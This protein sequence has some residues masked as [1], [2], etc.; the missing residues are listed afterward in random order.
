[1]LSPTKA[2]EGCPDARGAK[3]GQLQA[4]CVS[5]LFSGFATESDMD[6]RDR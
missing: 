4:R 3:P 2:A 1:M 6:D 5:W